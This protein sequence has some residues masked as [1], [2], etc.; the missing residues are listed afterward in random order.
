MSEQANMR[1]FSPTYTTQNAHL[2]VI[3]DIYP[4][5]SAG[6]LRPTI[7]AGGSWGVT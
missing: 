5:F 4:V 2:F 7:T 1:P 6:R 3:V